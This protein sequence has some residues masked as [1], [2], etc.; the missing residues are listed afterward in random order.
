M[1]W[2]SRLL[3]RDGFLNPSLIPNGSEEKTW[4]PRPLVGYLLRTVETTQHL[5]SSDWCFR[6]QWETWSSSLS[7]PVPQCPTFQ[8]CGSNPLL[9][10]HWNM[11]WR[12]IGSGSNRNGDWWLALGDFRDL[13][14]SWKGLKGLF[15]FYMGGPSSIGSSSALL[16]MCLLATERE[17]MAVTVSASSVS[18]LRA[19]LRE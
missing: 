9:T 4:Q 14:E 15:A 7:V 2:H 19:S 5:L 16:P 6:F 8:N 1:H 11:V 13:D 12:S 17:A 10:C 3:M 18:H